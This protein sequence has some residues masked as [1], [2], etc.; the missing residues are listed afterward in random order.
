MDTDELKSAWQAYDAKLEKSLQLNLHC[1]EAIQAQKV[2][3]TFTSLKIFKS[4]EIIIG[5][6]VIFFLGNFLYENLT[7]TYFVAAAAIVMLFCVVAI[8]GS[9]KQ[10]VLIN[11]TSYTRSV[12]YNQKKLAFLQ[13]SVLLQSSIIKYLRL[14]FLSLPFYTAYI[15][16]GFKLFFNTD[17]VLLG[18][19]YWWMAQI[20][21]SILFIPLSIWLYNKLSYKNM[22]IGWVRKLIESAGGKSISKAMDFIKELNEFENGLA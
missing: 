10:I 22:H 13:S 1:I 8:A 2:A 15:I 16:I 20:A 14:A 17:I 3:S 7:K 6:F 4:I 5:V 12:L 11:Q 9:V 21:L 19:K 18:D